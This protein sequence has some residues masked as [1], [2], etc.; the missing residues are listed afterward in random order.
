MKKGGLS[1]S[2]AKRKRHFRQTLGYCRFFFLGVGNERQPFCAIGSRAGRIDEWGKL[3][4]KPL[5]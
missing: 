5:K 2:L 1:A 3:D 4:L